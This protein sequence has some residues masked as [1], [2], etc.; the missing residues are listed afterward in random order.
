V[1]PETN[2]PRH[3][4]PEIFSGGMNLFFHRP[5]FPHHWPDA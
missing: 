1:N 4:R 2:G 5:F 3:R